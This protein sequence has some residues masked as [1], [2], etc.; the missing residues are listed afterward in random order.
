MLTLSARS[1][2][3]LISLA[4]RY[5]QRIEDADDP[6]IASVCHAAATTRTHHNRRV[7]IRV[8]HREQLMADLT[9]VAEGEQSPSVTEGQ[10]EFRGQARVAFLFTG[11]GSQYAGMGRSLMRSQPVFRE[12]MLRCNEVF[13]RQRGEELLPVIFGDDEDASSLVDRTDWTQPALYALEVSLARLWQSW[14]VEPALLMGHSVGE[15]AAAAIAGVFSIEDGLRLIAKRGE[16]M[17]QLPAGGSMAVVMADA[18]TVTDRIGHW[19]SRSDV[20]GSSAL[21]VAAVNIT[22]TDSG[23]G[24]TTIAGDDA[25]IQS[26]VADCEADGLTT[27]RLTV[28][29]A[30]HSHH[31]DPM[32]DEFEAFAAT[33]DMAMP[34]APLVSNVTGTL[35]DET[36]VTPNYWRNHVRQSVQFAGGVATMAGEDMDAMIEIGPAPI[37]TSMAR[38]CQSGAPPVAIASLRRGRD[39]ATS[40]LTA[41]AS[42]Y[43]AGGTID[44]HGFHDAWRQRHG[45]FDRVDLP[46]YPFDRQSYW[47]TGEGGNSERLDDGMGLNIVHP[48]LGKPIAA[49]ETTIYQARLRADSPTIRDHI[50]QNSTI[51]PGSGYTEMAF[52][53]AIDMFGPGN[54]CVEDLHFQQALFLGDVSKRVQTVVSPAA[55]DRSTFRIHSQSINDDK[56]HWELNAT[57]TIVRGGVDPSQRPDDVDLIAIRESCLRNRSHEEFYKIMTD[58]NLQY[59]PSY[60]ILDGLIKTPNQSIGAMLIGDA[61]R[62]QIDH[63]TIPPAIGDGAMHAAGGNVPLQKDGEFTPYAYLPAMIRSV[64]VYSPLTADLADQLVAVGVWQSDSGGDNPQTVVGDVLLTDA[65]GR[66]HV[67]YQGVMLRRLAMAG[68][69]RDHR[70]PQPMV[71]PVG[72]YAPR[73]NRSSSI[74]STSTHPTTR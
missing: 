22:P 67:H 47:L 23:D 2:A 62:S 26:F 9:C 52:A 19:A 3:S 45:S 41:A 50:V 43:V 38:R 74:R 20:G 10:V 58:R 64:S 71:V 11:Q 6:T 63:C 44:W 73:P 30:F 72:I 57:G 56:D 25:A 14:G 24:S 7:A 31:M 34:T 28:S 55:G 68:D 39:A 59:G 66:C 32:L 51:M 12:T 40:M 33:I 61:V 53:A 17:N 69:A 49:A 13:L 5:R 27:Q 42:F 60:Q 16:L 48:L 4:N 54:H 21:C 35:A 46:T 18:E 1:E 37:L 65:H 29:H 15:Y 8:D 70:D 36:I